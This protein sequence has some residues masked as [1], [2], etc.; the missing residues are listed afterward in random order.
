MLLGQGRFWRVA[1]SKGAGT[2]LVA[3]LRDSLSEDLKELRDFKLEV[4]LDKW[5]L[6]MK[7]V[8]TDRKLLGGV[9]LDF[10]KEADQLAT[11]LA[12]DRLFGE[13]QRV[14][15]DASASLVENGTVALTAVDVEGIGAS[16]SGAK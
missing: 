6:V 15:L 8:R 10:T 11:V 13:L 2:V 7:H 9:V 16:T 4:P 3:L 14:L 5:N 12:S 1:L